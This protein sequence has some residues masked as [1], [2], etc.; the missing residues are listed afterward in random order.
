[1]EPD[2]FLSEN[3]DVFDQSEREIVTI[4]ARDFS[5]APVMKAGFIPCPF[6]ATKKY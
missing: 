6:V 2:T 1:M 5:A 4:S 3:V